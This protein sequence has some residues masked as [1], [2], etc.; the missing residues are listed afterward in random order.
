MKISTFV[1]INCIVLVILIKCY[2]VFKL[3]DPILGEGGGTAFIVNVMVTC[4]QKCGVFT[5][6]Q[7][8]VLQARSQTR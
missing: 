1:L 5:S 7:H 6:R 8:N 4:Y 3:E 2:S